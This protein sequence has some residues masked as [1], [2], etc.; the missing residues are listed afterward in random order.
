MKSR[1]ILIL[2]QYKGV[3]APLCIAAQ[4]SHNIMSKIPAHNLIAVSVP[5]VFKTDKTE[6]KTVYISYE[7][8]KNSYDTTVNN[9][10]THKIDTHLSAEHNIFS[11]MSTKIINKTYTL[12]KKSI[13]QKNTALYNKLDKHISFLY[14]QTD[15][16]QNSHNEHSFVTINKMHNI[17]KNKQETKLLKSELY[18]TKEDILHFHK[19]KRSTVNDNLITKS[20][21]N[22]IYKSENKME[23]RLEMIENKIE[24]L[25]EKTVQTSQKEFSTI[26]EIQA[27]VHKSDLNLLSQKVY[28]LVLKQFKHE[29]RRKGNLYA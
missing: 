7:N 13:V 28:T 5:Q 29:Q 11:T 19:S 16:I 27:S 21:Q 26:T 2:P 3:K 9:Q 18:A 17:S 24:I 14:R 25:Q 4:F 20:V 1:S 23:T 6:N 15:T 12:H 10:I 8:Q 22:F